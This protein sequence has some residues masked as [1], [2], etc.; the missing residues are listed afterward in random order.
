MAVFNTKRI[1]YYKTGNKLQMLFTVEV[2]TRLLIQDKRFFC[3]MQNYACIIHQNRKI[4]QQKKGKI[5]LMKRIF[6]FK[7]FPAQGNA[8]GAREF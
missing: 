7:L 3:R 6:P 5:R 1:K 4:M 8:R 2:N